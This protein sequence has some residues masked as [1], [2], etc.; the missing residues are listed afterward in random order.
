MEETAGR[1]AVGR[2]LPIAREGFPFVVTPMAVGGLMLMAG[3]RRLG[4]AGIL[5]GSACAYF[6]RDPDRRAPTGDGL[7]VAPAD[8]R[9]MEVVTTPDGTRVSTFLSILDVHINRA[10][11]AG[12]IRRIEYHPGRF[13]P[14]WKSA[15]SHENEQNRIEIETPRGSVRVTQ[16]AGVLAWRIVSW[17]RSGQEVA[18]GAR[19]GLIRFGS[20][21]DLEV[22]PDVRILV[23][24]GA[25]LRAGE[26]VVGEW[27]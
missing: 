20:R 9:V 24:V 18:A 21:V 14:A 23:R 12:K 25:M 8:G 6:F 4:L 15:A 19:I 17:V 27:Q 26:T 3:F 2:S 13:L 22:P 11:C 1:T 16:I 10:P 5:L 7:L